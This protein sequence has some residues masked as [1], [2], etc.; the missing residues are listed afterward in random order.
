[1]DNLKTILRSGLT[2]LNRRQAS[3]QS[4]ILWLVAI[5]NFGSRDFW[6]FA[7]P[8]IILSE[9]QTIIDEL[10]KNNEIK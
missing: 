2:Y 5:L 6:F 4:T 9:I 10:R 8:A 1:M 7:I 3:A